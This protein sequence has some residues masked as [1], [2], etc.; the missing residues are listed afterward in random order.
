MTSKCIYLDKN[1][2]LGRS[3]FYISFSS[4]ITNDVSSNLTEK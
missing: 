3:F 4:Y 2:K 1:D